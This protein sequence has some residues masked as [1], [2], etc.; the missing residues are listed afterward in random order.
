MP[1]II[2]AAEQVG[3]HR[4]FETTVMRTDGGTVVCNST[5]ETCDHEI[6]VESGRRIVAQRT[7]AKVIVPTRAIGE[8]DLGR[9]FDSSNL[10]REVF[11]IVSENYGSIML[12]GPGTELQNGPVHGLK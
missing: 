10:V 1:I 3:I 7:R 4:V 5:A 11:Q 8:L 2:L 6:G 12:V 9:S